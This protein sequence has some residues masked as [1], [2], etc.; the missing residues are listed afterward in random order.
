[1]NLRQKAEYQSRKGEVGRG[2]DVT[3][4]FALPPSHF[5]IPPSPF[6][7]YRVLLAILL[8]WQGPAW[9]ALTLTTDN[10]SLFFG[11]MSLDESKEL[12]QFGSYHNEIT[13]S[14]SN[15]QTWYLKV[16]VLDPLR[17]GGEVMPPGQLEW[18]MET[19][20]GI[21]SLS[22]PNDYA[23][24]TVMPQLVY[25]SG[26]NEAAG[27]NIRLR[28]KYRMTVPEAQISG[29]YQATIRFTLNEVL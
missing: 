1:M 10:R 11:V 2:K 13:C 29:V 26:P 24:M 14:S 5:D 16:Q 8:A 20:D 7:L 12:A 17:A 18:Q 25:I 21:G 19:P 3:S 15:G 6:T 9:A 4:A 28:F 22:H 27:A 23:P